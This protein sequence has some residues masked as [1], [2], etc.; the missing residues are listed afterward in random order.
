MAEKTTTPR[1]QIDAAETY[2]SL[3]IP[4]LFAEWAPR[5]VAAAQIRGGE[6]VLDVACGTGVAAR[7]ALR[8]V[9]HGGS[10]AGVDSNGGMLEVARR[11]APRVDWRQAAAEALPFGDGAFDVVLCQFGLMFFS[12]R[13]MALREMMRVLVPGGRVAILV[14][15]QIDQAPAFATLAALLKQSAGQRAADALHA[16]FNLGDRSR[17]LETFAAAQIP[18]VAI[19]TYRGKARYPSVRSLVEAELRGWLPVMGVDL[20]EDQI[21]SVLVASETALRPLAGAGGELCFDMSAH[22]ATAT[23]G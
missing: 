3:F 19:T 22:L 6:R 9:A 5:I 23:R 16:P 1:A 11:L 8:L 4:A 14:W 15:D 21:Q 12:D 10:V 18:S 20:S 2:E 17:L 13:T 7:E